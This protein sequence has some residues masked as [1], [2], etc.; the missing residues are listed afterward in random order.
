MS[1]L[2][3]ELNIVIFGATSAIA[4]ATAR[5]WAEQSANLFL[6]ARSDEK[7]EVLKQD[8]KARGANKVITYIADLQDLSNYSNIYFELNQEFPVIDIVLIAQAVLG[9]QQESEND[10]DLLLKEMEL[11]FLGPVKLC[12]DLVKRMLESNRGTLAVISSVAG[13]RGRKSNYHYGSA[14]GALSLYLQGLRNRTAN[15]AVKVLTIKPGFVDTPMTENFKKGL[16]FVQPEVIAR[17]I[18][19]AIQDKKD[20]VYLPWFWYFIMLIIKIIPEK[21]FKKMSI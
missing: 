18:A 9:D 8:L 5:L 12:N 15:T 14:K 2:N 3:D 16:L 21:I 19:K 13:D 6:V 10:S 17:G 20:I 1:E 4:I 11:N 7:L